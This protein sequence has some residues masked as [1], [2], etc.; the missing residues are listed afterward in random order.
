M[1]GCFTLN[2]TCGN[3]PKSAIE[4]LHHDMDKLRS[5]FSLGCSKMASLHFNRHLRE[6]NLETVVI[7]IMDFPIRCIFKLSHFHINKTYHI[8]YVVQVTLD[9]HHILILGGKGGGGNPHLVCT[10]CFNL[11]HDSLTCLGFVKDK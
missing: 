11:G 4:G 1:C 10:T 6:K 3:S 7:Y 2:K 5:V 8:L 9:D